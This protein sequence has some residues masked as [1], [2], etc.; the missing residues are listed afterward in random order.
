MNILV[1]YGCS[2]TNGSML[3]GV[4]G[5]SYENTRNGF[6][7]MIAKK[8]GFELLNISKPGGSNR[9]I[10]RSV[11]DFV[12]NELDPKNEY[13]FLI[14]WTSKTRMEVRY[15]E[16]SRHR[17]VTLGDYVDQKSVPFTL[18]S[19][20]SLFTDKAVARLCRLT[21][22]LNDLERDCNDWAAYAFSL[23][24]VLQKNNI[25]YLM[26]NTCE[27]LELNNWN[28]PILQSLNTD[29]YMY[30]FDRDQAMVDY[31]LNKGIEKTPCWHFKEDGHRL[32]ADNLEQRLK[33][34]GYVK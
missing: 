19:K 28:K 8:H 16:E 31:L 3:D 7:G 4:N 17:H 11:I 23:Q 1:A 25:K 14:N 5:S 29:Y 24:N 26:S 27:E 10:H 18:G 20:A 15:A 6:P 33:D 30:P 21:P 34:L 32:W 2:H 12:N 22:Y 9:Y 13:L